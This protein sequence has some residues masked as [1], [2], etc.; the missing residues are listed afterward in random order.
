MESCGQNRF[1]SKVNK[2]E[3]KSIKVILKLVDVCVC[4][5]NQKEIAPRG[6]KEKMN[7]YN[8]ITFL[9]LKNSVI[10]YQFINVI[11]FRL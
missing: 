2:T 11:Y 1:I 7:E 10:F 4:N 8:F 6:N 9:S 5:T 3:S